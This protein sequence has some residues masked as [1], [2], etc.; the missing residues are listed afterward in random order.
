MRKG[1][2][3]QAGR[4]QRKEDR[5]KNRGNDPG[6]IAFLSRFLNPLRRGTHSTTDR[7]DREKYQHWGLRGGS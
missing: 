6:A 4:A 5:V 1:P 7:G 2:A 3:K